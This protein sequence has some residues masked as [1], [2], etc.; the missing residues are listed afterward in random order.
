MLRAG[1]AMLALVATLA[2]VVSPAWRPFGIA[3]FMALFGSIIASQLQ[4]RRLPSRLSA[5]SNGLV[6]DGT[7][8]A[9]AGMRDGYLRRV[10]QSSSPAVVIDG[11][12][13]IR[14]EVPDDATGKA[15]LAALELDLAHQARTFGVAM[16]FRTTKNLSFAIAGVVTLAVVVFALWPP[17]LIFLI[18]FARLAGSALGTLFEAGRVRIGADGVLV[19]SAF[20]TRF[21][22]RDR[23]LGIERDGERALVLRTTEGPVVLAAAEKRTFGPAPELEVDTHEEIVARVNELVA[24]NAAAATGELV[25]LEEALARPADVPVRE[26]LAGLAVRVGNDYRS[27]VA[28]GED[29]L[30]RVLETS[31]SRWARLGAAVVLARRRADFPRIRV[32]AE[33]S[34]EP[35]VRVALERIAAAGA[36]EDAIEQAVGEVEEDAAAGRVGGRAQ[37]TD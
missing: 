24:M 16:P 34:A 31:S 3:A 10:G 27:A 36:S 19:R 22:P 2:S 4:S 33:A 23:I 29:D 5:T 17:T 9:R 11:E 12:R 26:W 32:A 13:T 28:A 18:A 37:R 21:V 15:L 35:K 6:V 8:Y 20:S 25:A 7:L 30:A 14:V 1:A